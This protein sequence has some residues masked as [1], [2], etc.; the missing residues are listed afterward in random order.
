MVGLGGRTMKKT[1]DI[2]LDIGEVEL[3]NRNKISKSPS[4]KS[5]DHHR[6]SSSR[7]SEQHNTV[8]RIII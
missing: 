6:N 8:I 3:V 5:T 4:Y 7:S 2:S 1:K